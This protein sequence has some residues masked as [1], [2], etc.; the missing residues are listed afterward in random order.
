MITTFNTMPPSVSCRTRSRPSIIAALLALALSLS[1]LLSGCGAV[2]KISYNQGSSLA[3]R[4]LDGYVDFNDAQS[5][6]VRAALD[7]WFAWH[8]R[9]QLPDY[10][11]LL[12]RMRAEVLVNTTPERVCGWATELRHRV[13]A[14][15]EHAAPAL[16]DVIPTLTP[17]QIANVEKRYGEKNEEYRD[18][19]LQSNPAKRRQAA[20]DREIERGELLYGHLDDAQR[21]LVSRAVA[22]SPFDAELSYSERLRRQQDALAM[23]RRLATMRATRADVDAEMRAYVRRLDESPREDYRL[24][25]VRLTEYNCSFAAALQNAT[26]AAQRRAAAKTLKGYEDDLRAL[27]AEAST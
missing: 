7:E 23:L 19:Y 27:A 24:Y 13:D 25:S 10:A 6:R 17:Q 18:E 20:V 3:F 22:E 26:S 16:G 4:W 11:D 14:A 15:L 12:V 21:A 8:R 5:L 9:T 1:L 2:L